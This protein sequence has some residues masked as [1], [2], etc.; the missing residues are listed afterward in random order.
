MT[1]TR[2]RPR[3]PET[4][5]A[6]IAATAELLAE[7]SFDDVSVDAIA[8]RA[9][10][11]KQTIYRLWGSKASLVADAVSLGAIPL[12]PITL[13]DT[14]NLGADI[15]SYFRS[16]MPLIANPKFHSLVRALLVEQATVGGADSAPAAVTVAPVVAGWRRRFQAA[17]DSGEIPA[18]ADTEAAIDLII[19]ATTLAHLGT[20]TPDWQRV[21]AWAR[22]ILAGVQAGS[23]PAR[24]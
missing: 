10:A 12:P 1:A 5:A 21:D 19:A 8:A 7:R 3:S 11:G 2:G 24:A 22:V 15:R 9:G 17:K 16:T 6:I 20:V 13:P 14:G 23:A 18:D 4:R